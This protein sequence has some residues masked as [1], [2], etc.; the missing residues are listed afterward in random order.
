M[1]IPSGRPRLAICLSALIAGSSLACGGEDSPPRRPRPSA[2]RPSPGIGT[3]TDTGRPQA[4]TPRIDVVI[5]ALHVPDRVRREQQFAVR[6]EVSNSSR[7]LS[8]GTFSIELRAGLRHPGGATN[9]PLGTVR[10]GGL[11]AGETRVETA[12]VRAPHRSGQWTVT[13]TVRAVGFEDPVN[14]EMSVPL[15]VD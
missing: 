5:A 12:R 6:I 15:S 4:S 10:V 7:S 8:A 14:N 2:E 1:E 13:A 9:V 3:A 11:A